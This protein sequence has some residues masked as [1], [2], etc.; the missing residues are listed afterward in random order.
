[1]SGA[2][3]VST[4]CCHPALASRSH[5]TFPEVCALRVLPGHHP[6]FGWPSL[7][8]FAEQE[9]LL[10]HLQEQEFNNYTRGHY[11]ISFQGSLVFSGSHA[12]VSQDMV[13]NLAMIPQRPMRD[14]D[15]VLLFDYPES[16]TRTDRD[17][18]DRGLDSLS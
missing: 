18:D 15:L 7:L 14:F 17:I 13:W 2:F 1:M 6:R 5:R 12:L 8:R 11:N 3:A 16:C 10:S 9:Q 4:T